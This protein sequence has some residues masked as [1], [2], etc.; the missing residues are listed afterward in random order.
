VNTAA[1]VNDNTN[2]SKIKAATLDLNLSNLL[3]ECPD[4]KCL[5][6]QTPAEAR[7]VLTKIESSNTNTLSVEATQNIN[8]IK[9]NE[10]KLLTELG[11][12]ENYELIF[13]NPLAQ[14]KE[15]SAKLKNKSG[16]Y[17]WVN[18]VNGKKYI[19]SSVNIYKRLS[20]YFKHHII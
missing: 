15:I 11:L 19:G 1:I 9:F 3:A 7:G 20:D 8:L 14:R 4:K 17:C 18:K 12:P 6:K 13:L 10:I 5:F 16:V 2:K